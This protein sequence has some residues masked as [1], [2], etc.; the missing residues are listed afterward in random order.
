MIDAGRVCMKKKGRDAGEKCVIIN[1]LDNTFVEIVSKGRKQARK[2]NIVHLL[3]L[4]QTV[5]PKSEEQ[6]KAALS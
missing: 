2:V 6:I 5:D 1:V 3:P 4:D